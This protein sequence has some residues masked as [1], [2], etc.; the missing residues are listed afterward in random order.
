MIRPIHNYTENRTNISFQAKPLKL[1]YNKN[2]ILMA[3]R[4]KFSGQL[5]YPQSDGRLLVVEYINGLIT[6]A[7]KYTSDIINI[8]K[9]TPK[10][11][12]KINIKTDRKKIYEKIYTR[13][14]TGEL[15]KVDKDGQNV[16]NKE[17]S[18]DIYSDLPIVKKI[19]NGMILVGYDLQ[20]R[21]ISLTVFD[22]FLKSDY[23]YQDGVS[24]ELRAK[25]LQDNLAK[26]IK[27]YIE[28]QKLP[29]KPVNLKKID[30]KII[31]NPKS[32]ME[33]T[34]TVIYNDAEQETR[35]VSRDKNGKINYTIDLEY[36]KN[37]NLSKKFSKAGDNG[38]NVTEFFEN[39]LPVHTVAR[40]GDGT[41][42]RSVKQKYDLNLHLKTEEVN[43]NYYPE[44][45]LK[46]IRKDYE[47]G[48]IHYIQEIVKF[49]NGDK[50]VG[51]QEYD[52]NT[53]QLVHS[54]YF[55]PHN[56]K[57]SAKEFERVNIE[58]V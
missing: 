9:F 41:I 35:V 17:Y 21:K 29:D 27:N 19:N 58:S 53:E 37:G 57:I 28:D 15:F 13:G 32:A 11:E 2:N 52:I 8:L 31:R 12:E 40:R 3:G 36:D 22:K 26:I 4:Q 1:T 16:F 46:K 44:L 38:V 24:I 34:Y 54:E 45:G 14:A 5:G 50:Y 47:K 10:G 51:K 55:G 18:V 56:K 23:F 39:G 20:N 48:D 7:E 25:I 43:Y 33:K 42:V 49:N 6:K 30:R